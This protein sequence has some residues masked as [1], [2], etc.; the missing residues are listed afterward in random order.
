MGYGSRKPVV[1]NPWLGY[2]YGR[3]LVIAEGEIPNVTLHFGAVVYGG[4]RLSVDEMR[5]AILSMLGCSNI[6]VKFNLGWTLAALYLVLPGHRV[7]DL[8]TQLVFQHWCRRLTVRHSVWRDM[9]IENIV[10][11]YDRRIPSMFYDIDL[12]TTP[13]EVNPIRKLYYTAAI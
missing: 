10:N 8:S 5:A 1:V 13:N 6:I 3:T 7:V 9:L 12:Y 4:K 2:G 11:S